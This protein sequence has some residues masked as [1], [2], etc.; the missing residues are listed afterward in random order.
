[1]SYNANGVNI[2]DK[3]YPLTST[4][5]NTNISAGTTNFKVNNVDISN[6]YVGIGTNSNIKVSQ[7]YTFNYSRNET[8]IGNL[9]ELN[10]PVFVTGTINTEYKMFPV[11][12]GMVI[13][14]LKNTTL[15][16]NYKIDCSF[17]MVGGGGGGGRQANSN[18]GGGGG[19][20]GLITGSIQGYTSGINLDI[21]IGNGGGSDINGF[22]TTLTYSSTTITAKGGGY[23]GF[24]KGD[25]ASVSG[26]SSGGAGS[27]SSSVAYPGTSSQPAIG[28]TSIFLNMQSF[29]NVGALG[30]DQ[31]NDSG[32]GGGGG[33]AGAAA[34]VVNNTSPGIGGA[35]KIITYDSTSFYLAG[36]GGGGGREDGYGDG[37]GGAG[38]GGG[39]GKGGGPSNNQGGNGFNGVANTGGGGGGA[40]N[41]AGIGGT[42]GSG[43]V[44]F[45]ILANNVKL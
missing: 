9:F 42:G 40:Q 12:N 35:G 7:L 36:G 3:F 34:V 28:N 39:G 23:G 30:N 10:L 4:K 5:S 13:Q 41:T 38:G 14:I 6:N 32:A 24:G 8:N 44:I 17:C 43:T 20:G 11:T 25:S 29:G 2:L 22:S 16:F 37:I 15:K 45:Y 27:Y 26:S 31:N 1:M 21:V 19:A 18:A 33:G